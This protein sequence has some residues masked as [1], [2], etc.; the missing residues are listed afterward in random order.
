MKPI[1][2]ALLFISAAA[3]GLL[4]GA[5]WY[6]SGTPQTEIRQPGG[7]LEFTLNSAQGPI[8]LSDSDGQI[9]IMYVGYVSCPDV[10][11]TSLSRL[12]GALHQLSDSDLARVQPFFLSVD[13]KR[14]TPDILAMYSHYFHPAITG[15]TGSRQAVDRVVEHLQAFYRIVPLDDSEFGYAIDHSANIYVLNENGALL[16]TFPDTLTPGEMAERIRNHLI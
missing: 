13:I 3:L 8:S 14:D 16:E 4:A 15:I 10:C 7:E 6:H 9:R 5:A 1:K 12:G 2:Y 11:P